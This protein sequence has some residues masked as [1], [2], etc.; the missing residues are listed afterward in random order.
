MA[1]LLISYRNYEYFQDQYFNGEK[2]FGVISR[3]NHW[4]DA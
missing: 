4:I 1:N 3:E 2:D